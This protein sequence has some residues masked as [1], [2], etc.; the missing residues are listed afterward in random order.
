MLT[1]YIVF[2]KLKI[3]GKIK[4]GLQKIKK[5]RITVGKKK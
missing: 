4:K 2:V 1:K 5:A 3:V